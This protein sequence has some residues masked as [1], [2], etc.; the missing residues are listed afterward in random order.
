M[1]SHQELKRTIKLSLIATALLSSV[2][3]AQ[4]QTLEAVEVWE[5][6]VTSSSLNVKSST[7]ETK[8][9]DHLSDLLRD[10]P[11]VDVGGTSSINNRI[12]I[13]G[14]EDENLDITIDG[15]KISNVN[16]FHHIGN[17]LVN[18]DILKKADI[19]VGTNFKK[20]VSME[21]AF[22]AITTLTTA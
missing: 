16:M 9:A 4:E 17:L 3:I 2:A 12:A 10:L 6:Q 7:I 13:R 8:Q 19:Q 5:T 15:A 22:K 14:I 18:P 20:G 11:G 1:F 21:H